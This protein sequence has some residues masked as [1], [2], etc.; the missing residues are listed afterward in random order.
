MC[1]IQIGYLVSLEVFPLW[2]LCSGTAP[3]GLGSVEVGDYL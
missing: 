3:D 1:F 2:L